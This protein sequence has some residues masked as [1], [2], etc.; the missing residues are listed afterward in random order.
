MTYVITQACVGSKDMACIEVC[1]V[2]CIHELEKMLVIH[3]DE[4]IDC[5]ACVPECPQEAIYPDDDLPDR[6]RRWVAAN[7]AITDGSDAA[8]RAVDELL[9]H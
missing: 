6:H 5:G 3:P 9:A 2:D 8:Q 4:C 1:P 7:A